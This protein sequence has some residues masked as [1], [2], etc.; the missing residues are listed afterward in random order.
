AFEDFADWHSNAS[1]LVSVLSDKA[2]FGDLVLDITGVAHLFGGEAAMLR[3][4][5]S[6]LFA[7]NYTVSGAIAP[8]IG[9]AWAISHYARSQVVTDEALESTLDALPIQALR[10]DDKHIATLSQM[11]L[12][13]IGQLRQRPRKSLQARFGTELLIR[14]DQAYGEI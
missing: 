12:T 2:E 7:L 9:A 11:G 5:L 8:T 14:I 13:T 1:P 3:L 6:R 4:L 10:L